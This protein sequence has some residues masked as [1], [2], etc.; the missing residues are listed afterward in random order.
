[1]SRDPLKTLYN[2]PPNIQ[3]RVES[4]EE[5]RGR[6]PTKENKIAVKLCAAVLFAAVLGLVMRYVNGCT[7]FM[8]AF[9][10][11]FLVWTVVNTWDA[12]AMDIIWFCHDPHFVIKGTE[13]MV[14][15]Y[16]DYWFHIRG[17]LMGELIALPVCAAAGLFVKLLS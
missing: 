11:S 13:D 4:L 7:G 10:Q 9:L 1:M 12:V 15:D 5:Y 6:I 3:R 17:S 16:R 8:G 2:Y 14:S